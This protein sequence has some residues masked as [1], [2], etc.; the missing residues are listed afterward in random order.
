[1][2]NNNN[3]N[4]E[5]NID[6]VPAIVFN[7]ILYKLRNQDEH[8]KNS[9]YLIQDI[10]FIQHNTFQYP[11]IFIFRFGRTYIELTIIVLLALNSQ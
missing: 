11:I 8:Y 1:M 2:N 4:N 9:K 6:C 7:Y 5:G 10:L 3:P